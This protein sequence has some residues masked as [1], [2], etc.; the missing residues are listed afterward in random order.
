MDVVNKVKE[1][2]SR[3]PSKL[4]L[5]TFPVSKMVNEIL[6]VRTSKILADAG[7]LKR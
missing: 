2:C 4:S 6:E 1:A 3:S 5:N 7:Y